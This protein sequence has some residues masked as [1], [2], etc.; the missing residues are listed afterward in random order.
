MSHG[1]NLSSFS[2]D[3]LLRLI[4]KGLLSLPIIPIKR[5]RQAVDPIF[6]SAVQRQ[7]AWER[8]AACR[9]GHIV[10]RFQLASTQSLAKASRGE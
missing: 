1:H 5:P 10:A 8:E 7:H 9:D 6:I 3:I 4:V 2:I